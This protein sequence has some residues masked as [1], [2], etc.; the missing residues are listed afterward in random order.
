MVNADAERRDVLMLAET[1]AEKIVQRLAR[2]FRRAVE[3]RDVERGLGGEFAGRERVQVGGASRD[4]G[5]GKFLRVNLREE[6]LRGLD[7]LVVTARGRGFAKAGR[8]VGGGE[9]NEDDG[10]DVFGRTT[11]NRPSVGELKVVPP[12][13]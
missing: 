12:E 6:F 4:I 5:E 3:E 7:G 2:K 11:R 10:M 1:E 13:F 9:A 8:A